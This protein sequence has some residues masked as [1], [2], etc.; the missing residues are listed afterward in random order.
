VFERCHSNWFS[1]CLAGHHV[2]SQVK[3]DLQTLGSATVKNW[4]AL[5]LFFMHDLVCGGYRGCL[6]VVS[7][8]NELHL[9]LVV[10]IKYTV[11][12]VDLKVLEK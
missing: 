8:W 9:T 11:I 10:I 1:V 2:T 4:E 3:V 6:V 12:R 7:S 5:L